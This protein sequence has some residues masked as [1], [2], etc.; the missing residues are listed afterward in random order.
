MKKGNYFTNIPDCP[1]ACG[2]V[3]PP[4]LGAFRPNPV[5]ELLSVLGIDEQ[6]YYECTLDGFPGLPPWEDFKQMLNG[7]KP[8]PLWLELHIFRKCFSS[9]GHCWQIVGGESGPLNGSYLR[10]DGR[11][12]EVR[13]LEN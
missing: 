7:L 4:S 2:F 6:S 8:M 5:K 12:I 10:A 3:P 1:N 13:E 9:Y 11:M